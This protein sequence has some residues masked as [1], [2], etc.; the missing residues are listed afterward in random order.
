MHMKVILKDHKVVFVS[1]R[2]WEKGEIKSMTRVTLLSM[3]FLAV[4]LVWL[5]NFL[6]A[7]VFHDR[8]VYLS[9]KQKAL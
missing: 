4:G 8:M 6:H 9:I 1:E 3:G 5:G 7:C 2:K